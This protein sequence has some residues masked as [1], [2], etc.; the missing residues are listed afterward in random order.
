MVR[1]IAG[2]LIEI[3]KGREYLID[4]ILKSKQRINAGPTAPSM[5]LFLKNVDYNIDN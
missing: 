5:G 4:E 3:G 2:T 1:I